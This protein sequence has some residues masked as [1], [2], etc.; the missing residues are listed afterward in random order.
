MSQSKSEEL[1]EAVVPAENR[2]EL[3]ASSKTYREYLKY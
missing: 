2:T 3:W 1:N